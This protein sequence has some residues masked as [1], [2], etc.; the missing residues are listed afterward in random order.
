MLDRTF[1]NCLTRSFIGVKTFSLPTK[2]VLLATHNKSS[3]GI[4]KKRL[5]EDLHAAVIQAAAYQR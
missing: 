2:A 4:R 1:E 3:G 5:R